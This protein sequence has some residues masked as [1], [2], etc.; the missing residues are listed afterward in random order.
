MG[1]W[2][3]RGLAREVVVEDLGGGEYRLCLFV[4]SVCIALS[5][6]LL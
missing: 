3:V 2:P 6:V 5:N 1:R 4:M